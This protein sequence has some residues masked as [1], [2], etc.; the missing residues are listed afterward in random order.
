MSITA[1][2]CVRSHYA[3]LL[4]GR[5][6]VCAAILP[7]SRSANLQICVDEEI[8]LDEAILRDDDCTAIGVDSGR[9]FN[10]SRDVG[11]DG[12]MHSG[13]FISQPG[14]TGSD[15]NLEARYSIKPEECHNVVEDKVKIIEKVNKHFTYV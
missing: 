5:V 11:P 9:D 13:F 14:T 4:R 6:R 1:V 15:L 10:F 8:C 3:T 12:W 2:S 7:I